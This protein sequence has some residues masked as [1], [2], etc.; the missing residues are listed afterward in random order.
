MK[1][2]SETFKELGIAFVFP[3]EIKGSE[4]NYTYLEDSDGY[5][6]RA[7]YNSKGKKTYFEDSTGFWLRAEYNSKGN[8]T[9]FETSTGVK[10]GT[11]W[12]LSLTNR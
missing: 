5:W 11:P 3:I 8:E 1:K 10:R 7:E 6:S 12:S 4:G 2:L 9:Y